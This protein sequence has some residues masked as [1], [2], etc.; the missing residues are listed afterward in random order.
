MNRSAL[1]IVCLTTGILVGHGSGA[2][3]TARSSDWIT[4]LLKVPYS[5]A[6]CLQHPVL[7]VIEQEHLE[8]EINRSVIRTA[9]TIGPERFTRGLGTHAN[10]DILLYSPTPMERFSCTLGVDNNPSTAGGTSSVVFSVWSDERCLHRT[11]TLRCGQ[12]AVRIDIET[13]GVTTLRL[14]VDNAGDGSAF[15]HANRAEAKVVLANGQTLWLDAVPVGTLP[16]NKSPFPFSFV[17]DGTTS[18]EVL[19]SWRRQEDAQQSE[20]GKRQQIT[21]WTEPHSGLRV[22]WQVTRFDTFPA[23]GWILSFENTGTK[24]TG[25]LE[26]VDCMD[27]TLAAPLKR[28]PAYRLHKTHGAPSNPEDFTTEVIEVA[29]GRDVRM[30]GSMGRSSNSDF[31]FYRVE[32]GMGSLIIA[33]GWSGLWRS[34]IACASANLHLAAGLQNARFF[35]QPGEKVRLPRILLFQWPDNTWESNAQFRQLIYQHYAAKRNGRP[36][37]PVVFSNTCFTEYGLAD[38]ANAQNQI[39]LIQT[40]GPLGVEAAVTDAGWMEG[41]QGAWWKGCG[42]WFVRKDNYPDGMAPVAKAAHEQ[43]M[44]Y[45]LWAEVETVSNRPR[46]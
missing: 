41:S 25:I 15:D 2:P 1:W 37:L 18:D 40:F 45:G 9:L 12:Q 10:S 26:E 43:S 19:D 27:V 34:D 31:P 4:Q 38:S 29:D 28:D 8:L 16:H 46:P 39:S 3:E 24:N 32:T 23:A 22:I 42:N 5:D 33:V 35:L 36:P 6:G 7:Q 13:G 14:R 20:G 11:Q 17:Y 21:T 44:I 30:G